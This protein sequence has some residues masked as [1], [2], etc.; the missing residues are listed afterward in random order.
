MRLNL[1]CGSQPLAGWVNVDAADIP[2]VDVV[3]DLDVIP[4]PFDDAS[5]SEV[6]AFDVFEHVGNPLGFMAECHRVLQ[7]GGALYIHT[8]YW[9]AENGFTDPTHRRFCTER[10]FDYWIPGT[11]YHRRYG[12]AYGGHAHPFALLSCQVEDGSELAFTLRKI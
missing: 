6:R 1:G 4:W 3:H 2:G 7:P 10:T 9:R 8:S 12:A 5:M 11:D